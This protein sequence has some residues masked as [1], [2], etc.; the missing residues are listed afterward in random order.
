MIPPLDRPGRA[1][2]LAL[3]TAAIAAEC[4]GTLMLQASD[5]FTRPGPSLGVLAGYGAAILLFSRA[6]EH[7]LALGVA[8][9]TLTGCGLVAATAASTLLVGDVPAPGQVG[10]LALILIGALLMAREPS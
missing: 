6:L 3:L 5:G 8:Y 1:W 7:G 9:G 10:G 2:G 4:S